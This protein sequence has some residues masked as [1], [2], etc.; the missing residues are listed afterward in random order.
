MKE[1]M[2]IMKE[3]NRIIVLA[4]EEAE[5]LGN[6]SIRPDHLFLAIL[7]DGN[8]RAY[9]ILKSLN[10]NTKEIKQELDDLYRQRGHP[11]SGFCRSPERAWQNDE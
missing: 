4:R 7:R 11:S 2:Y 5:R 9:R 10:V 3:V 8:N 6:E 1:N